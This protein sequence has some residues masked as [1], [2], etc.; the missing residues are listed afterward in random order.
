MAPGLSFERTFPQHWKGDA[1]DSRRAIWGHVLQDQ[2]SS[3]CLA[4]RFS[5]V[6]TRVGTACAFPAPL[7]HLFLSTMRFL[8]SQAR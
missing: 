5:E 8:P 4:R 6:G 7:T 2:E 1:A 3:R